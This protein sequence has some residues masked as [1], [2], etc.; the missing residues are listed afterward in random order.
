MKKCPYCGAKLS[1]ESL[2]CTECG[3][4]LSKGN[5]CPHCGASVND[6]DIFCMECG[7]KIDEVTTSITERPKCPHCGAL[8]NEG[9][10]YCMECG[11]IIDEKK[12]SNANDGVKEKT[13]QPQKCK[14]CPYCGSI[15]DEKDVL[16]DNC[17]RLVVEGI[18][19]A[20]EPEP[21]TFKDYLPFLIGVILVAGLI[22]GALWYWDSSNKRVEREKVAAAREAFVKDSLEQV[23]QDS[24]NLVAQKEKEELDAKRYEDFKEKFTFKN[25]LALLGNYEKV[26]FAKKCGFEL[27]YKEIDVDDEIT[28]EEYV[29]GFDIEKGDKKE[30]GYE[31]V[32][33]SNHACYL[34]Y[35]LDTSTYASMN[36][37]DSADAEYFQSLAKEYGLLVYDNAMYV[38]KKKMP[39]GYHYVDSLDWGGEY[40]PDYLIGNTQSNNGWYEVG[41]GM[42]F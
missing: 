4:E 10:V 6:G 12:T 32:A 28:C 16:C 33:K 35:N 30:S 27:I 39:S 18:E 42:D 1:D 19:E 3:K 14:Q 20:P 7:M 17:G 21:K 2:F 13:P 23:R 5:L 37:K 15:M 40:D 41:I 34:I 22:G 25:F 11:K 29:Y 8:V 26:S 31:I 36:F 9:D 38:P 24:L